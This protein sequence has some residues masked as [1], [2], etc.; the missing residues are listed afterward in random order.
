MRFHSEF[1]QQIGN[2][3][4]EICCSHCPQEEVFTLTVIR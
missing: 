2:I 4:R 1:L 3:V